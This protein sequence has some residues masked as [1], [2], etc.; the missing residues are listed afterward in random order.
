MSTSTLFQPFTLKNLTLPNRFVM[1]P[2]TRGQSP[3]NVPSDKNALYYQARAQ[4]E[5]G[6]IISE[7]T[8]IN[9][10]AAENNFSNPRSVPHFYG[11]A[12]ILGWKKVVEAVHAAGGKFAPQ[13]WHVGSVRQT[14]SHPNPEKGGY[15]PSAVVHPHAFKSEVPV[16]MTEK[17][18]QETIED[19]AKAA[20]MAK[21]IG[22]D[23]IELHGAHG[24]LLD[25]FFWDYTNQR[26]DIYGG[27]TLAERTRFACEVINAVRKSVG[28]NFPILLRYSQWKL[29]AYQAR[30]AHTPEELASFLEPLVDAGVDI[31]H[32]STRKLTT[33]EFSDSTE[34]LAGWTKKITGKPVIAVGSLGINLDFIQTYLGEKNTEKA[35]HQRWVEDI[36]ERMEKGEF[37]L[38]ALGRALIADPSLVKKIQASDYGSIVDYDPIMLQQY[39]NVYSY[40]ST[41]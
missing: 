7:G 9:P 41:K 12:A 24:Y 39:P 11:E 30:L 29:S 4:G 37:D 31:F 13:L 28:E 36:A 15:G 23:G 10:Y 22:C 27:K 1:A 16:V 38:V 25:Q 40:T 5:V 33:P 3:D 14:G 2:M 19:Y 6:L 8:Y 35:S 34:H 17:D 20:F 21:Q 26:Q 18:I 32:C